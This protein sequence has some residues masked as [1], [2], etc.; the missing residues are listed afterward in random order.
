MKPEQAGQADVK[1]VVVFNKFLTAQSMHMGAWSLP[2]TSISSAWGSG[3][4][5]AAEDGDL[6]RSIQEFGKDI[7]FFVRWTNVDFGS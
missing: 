2:A 3:A 5:R 7:E 6:F 4:T 1:G